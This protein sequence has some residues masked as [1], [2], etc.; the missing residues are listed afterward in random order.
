MNDE[1]S[2]SNIEWKKNGFDFNERLTLKTNVAKAL[3]EEK[4]NKNTG[5]RNVSPSPVNLPNGIKKIRKK[6][7][8]VYD[9]DEDEDENENIQIFM[10]IEINEDT[11]LMNALGADEKQFIK[12]Q[13]ELHQIRLRQD[14]GKL[15]ALFQADKLVKENGFKGLDKEVMSRNMQELTVN[16]D[17]TS[18]AINENLAKTL[19]LKGEKLEDEKA[20][21]LLNGV[22]QVRLFAGERSLQGMKVNDVLNIGERKRSKKEMAKLILEKSGR[23]DIEGK[24]IHNPQKAIQ[25]DKN[26]EAE[27]LRKMK[28]QAQERNK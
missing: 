11:P 6:I 9:E 4:K 18:K 22:R 25:N 17:F 15:N 20:L 5:L 27:V 26:K 12:Q 10:P 1:S 16:A 7:K 24:T 14:T 3:A 28:K 19:K 13:E 8:E 23:V 2:N 21:K